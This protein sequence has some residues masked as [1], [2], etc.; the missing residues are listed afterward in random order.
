[1]TLEQA[2]TKAAHLCSQSEKAPQEIL[3]KLV[4][5]GIAK[6]AAEEI[7]EWLKKEKFLSEERFAHA[8]VN[9]KFKYEH[10]GRI[11]IA[12]HLRN[13]RIEDSIIENTLDD[14]ISPEEY[15]ETLKSLLK[16]KLKG[17][18][19]PLAENDRAKL[20]RFA[21]QRGFETG[22]VSKALKAIKVNEDDSDF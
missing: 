6:G 10:W 3:D 19:M 15:L 18:E 9:D 2:K 5:W 8:F 20:Y 1:M 22:F 21:A 7:V 11:K 16:M 12:Y 13:K 14:I 17:M 4:T